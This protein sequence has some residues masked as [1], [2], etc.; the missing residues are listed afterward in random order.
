VGAIVN[1]LVLWIAGEYGLSARMGVAIHPELN[2][3][4]LYPRLVWGGL[5]GLL[6]VLPWLQHRALLR[7]LV[8]SLAPTL[9]ALLYFYPYRLHKGML[10]QEL[11]QLTPVLV[12]TVNALWGVVTALWFRTVR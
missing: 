7:G 4:W 11:G 12:A 1:S 9:F 10:G 6:L 5:W 3:N 2:A 8:F